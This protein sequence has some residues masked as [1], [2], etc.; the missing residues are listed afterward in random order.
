MP[1]GNH[2]AKRRGKSPYLARGPLR[3]ALRP[4]IHTVGYF[5]ILKHCIFQAFDFKRE[6][7]LGMNLA[8]NQA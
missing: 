4:D 8:L 1:L 2:R 3:A 7:N 6:I 5:Y